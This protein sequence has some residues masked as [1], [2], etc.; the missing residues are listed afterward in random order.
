MQIV[1]TDGHR[2]LRVVEDERRGALVTLTAFVDRVAFPRRA[3]FTTLAAFARAGAAF[4]AVDFASLS[5]I[6]A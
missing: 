5:A 2:F 4:F 6:A 1:R 3:A